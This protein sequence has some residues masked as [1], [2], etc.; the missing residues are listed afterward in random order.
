MVAT[1]DDAD[2][3]GVRAYRRIHANG[4]QTRVMIIKVADR[5]YAAV[6]YDVDPSEFTPLQAETIAYDPT[7]EGATER[8]ERWMQQH[9]KGVAQSLSN[10][11]GGESGS[12]TLSKITAMAG[13]LND[14]GN[15][16]RENA[17][18]QQQGGYNKEDTNE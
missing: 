10:G 7:L 14:Y 6:A 2:D 8:A 9:P 3:D 17:Q 18:Q 11:D 4:E 15:D 5:D 1:Y 12:S 16:L 13:K